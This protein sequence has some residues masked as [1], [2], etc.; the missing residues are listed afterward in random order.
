MNKQPKR[1]VSENV[2]MNSVV[3]ITSK[4]TDLTIEKIIFAYNLY[5]SLSI[6][7]SVFT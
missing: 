4:D 3:L 6:F 7:Q 2:I 5:I 1:A